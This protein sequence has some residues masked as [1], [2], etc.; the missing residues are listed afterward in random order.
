MLTNNEWL[1]SGRKMCP[2]DVC[3][4]QEQCHGTS[5]KVDTIISGNLSHHMQQLQIQST[6]DGSIIATS[7]PSLHQEEKASTFLDKT[8]RTTETLDWDSVLC[9]LQQYYTGFQNAIG[10]LPGMDIRGS[11]GSQ[12]I[13]PTVICNE[14][15]AESPDYSQNTLY[16]ETVNGYAALLSNDIINSLLGSSSQEQPQN[17]HYKA[18]EAESV[19]C[20]NSCLQDTFPTYANAAQRDTECHWSCM[21]GGNIEHFGA[22]IQNISSFTEELSLDVISEVYQEVSHM[23]GSVKVLNEDLSNAAVAVPVKERE[24]LSSPLS[25]SPVEAFSAEMVKELTAICVHKAAVERVSFSSTT[26]LTKQDS[27]VRQ[28]H[29]EDS[30]I[31]S[32][33]LRCAASMECAD[34]SA[35]SPVMQKATEVAYKE[36][37]VSKWQ[38]YSEDYLEGNDNPRYCEEHSLPMEEDQS[39]ESKNSSE[40]SV[41]IAVTNKRSLDY[42]T[43]PPSTPMQSRKGSSRRSFVRKLKRGLAKEFLPKPP[44]PTPKEYASGISMGNKDHRG[45]EFVANLIK[46]LALEVSRMEHEAN[47]E[48][49]KREHLVEQSNVCASVKSLENAVTHYAGQ[50]A[51]SVL[52][53][54]IE[55]VCSNTDSVSEIKDC[56]YCP[57]EKTTCM[58]SC[59]KACTNLLGEDSL[60]S[61]SKHSDFCFN[62]RESINQEPETP[63]NLCLKTSYDTSQF[64]QRSKTAN[65]R[66]FKDTLQRS[67]S[68]RKYSSLYPDG[69]NKEPSVTQNMEQSYIWS[70]A[71]KLCNNIFN[72]WL[73]QGIRREK[74]LDSLEHSTYEFSK[75]NPVK[76]LSSLGDQC[77]KDVIQDTLQTLATKASVQT[78]FSHDSSME[79]VEK[80]CTSDSH[81]CAPTPDNL[82]STAKCTNQSN[83]KQVHIKSAESGYSLELLA[84]EHMETIK[85]TLSSQEGRPQISDLSVNIL[86]MTNKSVQ[87]FVSA[88]LQSVLCEVISAPDGHEVS[89]FSDAFPNEQHSIMPEYNILNQAMRE[90]RPISSPCQENL[91]QKGNTSRIIVSSPVCSKFC[92]DLQSQSS[93][94]NAVI[95]KT[96]NM[97]HVKADKAYVNCLVDDL[98]QSCLMEACRYN[99]TDSNV[100]KTCSQPPYTTYMWNQSEETRSVQLINESC[101]LE[102]SHIVNQKVSS[103][104]SG[105]PCC[106]MD[107]QECPQMTVSKKTKVHRYMGS[108]CGHSRQASAHLEEVS[109]LS[110]A[111]SCPGLALENQASQKDICRVQLQVILQWAAASQLYIPRLRFMEPVEGALRQLPGLAKKVTEKDWKVGHLLRAVQSYCVENKK[112]LLSRKDVTPELIDWLIRRTE[113]N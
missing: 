10:L 96:E 112:L 91:H 48:V 73:K 103:S 1:Q 82:Q 54:G 35:Q 87:N 40:T 111:A 6:E 84:E 3:V 63:K 4:S 24:G 43:A 52:C 99:V 71:E 62:Q 86:A 66:P 65:R 50:L 102:K 47:E 61:D 106:Y 5:K 33:E 22:Q 109:M 21:P 51:N 58:E 42:P 104:I 68:G 90:A 79:S 72:K 80:K 88:L 39:S 85:G 2:V 67:P 25:C 108:C 9:D 107:T 70:Y 105:A 76:N 27:S 46:S 60:V 57:S 56:F 59:F 34:I 26:S 77:A 41:K 64:A 78:K 95:D 37:A 75:P 17:E 113:I 98:L 11:S 92:A 30:G 23:A 18:A 100:P 110:E 93:L 31:S 28:C 38:T 29:Q 20:G 69:T 97:S 53:L 15:E 8:F 55:A 89:I 81:S 36:T 45:A 49:P 19:Y 13:F 14:T 83:E 74:W 32:S 94:E 16:S 44:P 7:N 101:Q 12:S